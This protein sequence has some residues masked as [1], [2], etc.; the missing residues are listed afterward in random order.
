MQ[1][2][3]VDNV[4][5][6][7]D[8]KSSVLKDVSFSVSQGDFV[9][10]VGPNGAGKSTL[11]KIILGFLKPLSGNVWLFGKEI[12]SFREW[13]R[14]GYVPQRLSV[15]QAFPATVEE[16]LSLVASRER[17]SELVDF[18]HMKTFIHKQ[19][20]ELSGGQQQ[21]VLLGMAL[22]SDPELLLLDEPTAG[23]DVHARRHI[24]EILGD[25]STNRGRTVLMISHDIGLVLRSVD[26]VM[27][28][29]KEVLYYGEPDGAVEVIEDMFGL[30]GN[31]GAS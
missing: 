15:E 10:I 25:I 21:L 18:L 11:F 7:Y 6:S 9:G 28:L 22:A 4:C 16:M 26:K 31:Y 23:L 12:A 30:R 17:L 5:F 24:M 29:N 1:V 3:K 20:Q 19:F 13:S 27:C 8:G 2:I 14:I